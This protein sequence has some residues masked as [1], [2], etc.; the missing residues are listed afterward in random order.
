MIGSSK[1]ARIVSSHSCFFVL[2][3]SKWWSKC[4]C[5]LMLMWELIIAGTFSVKN[6]DY[7]I[8]LLCVETHFHF[9]MR[10]AYFSACQLYCFVSSYVLNLVIKCIL[11]LHSLIFGH[12]RAAKAAVLNTPSWHNVTSWSWYSEHV[13][14]QSNISIQSCFWPPDKIFTLPASSIL[15]STTP[16]KNTCLFIS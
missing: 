16:E 4:G 7:S 11:N 8:F 3:S 1:A 12:L 5:H 9:A 13:L 15:V 14:I 6:H 2:V 10:A